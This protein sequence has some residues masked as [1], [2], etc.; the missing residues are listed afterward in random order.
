MYCL[1]DASCVVAEGVGVRP[2]L[3]EVI[4]VVVAATVQDEVIVAG[5]T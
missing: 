3:A 5:G 1:P 2:L 4:G